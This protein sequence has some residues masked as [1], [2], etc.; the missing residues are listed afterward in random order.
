MTLLKDLLDINA[1]LYLIFFGDLMQEKSTPKAEVLL[2]LLHHLDY[3]KLLRFQQDS[4]IHLQNSRSVW[5]WYLRT[6]FPIQLIS[7][8]MIFLS[9]DPRLNIQMHKET[10]KF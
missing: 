1:I 3:F 8:L 7:S 10:L 4:P 2:H 5:S 9:K 6:K